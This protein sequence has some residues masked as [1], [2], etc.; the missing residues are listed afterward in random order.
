MIRC[1]ILDHDDT[2][3]DSTATIHYPAHR[4][5]MAR[6]RPGTEPVSLEEWFLRNFDPGISH[7]LEVELGLSPAE[8]EIEMDI[9]RAH[10]A[11]STPHFY[12]GLIDLLRRFRDRGGLIAVVSHSEEQ[13]I[14]RHYRQAGF[15]PDAIFGWGNDPAKRKPSPWAVERIR[16]RFGLAPDEV[17]VVDDLKPGVL[18]ARSAGVRAAAAGWAHSIPR[19]QAWMRANC[20]AYLPAVADLERL[21][22]QGCPAGPQPPTAPPAQ[23]P[24]SVGA[25]SA[26]ANSD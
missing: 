25:W 18:M 2:A 19:I 21:L 1:L 4:E 23:D 26:S 3:V 8:L 14:E 5:C 13:T 6:L 11:R 17:V 24:R 7:Y 15:A 9:W 12:P 20:E 10:T 22:Q 16:E